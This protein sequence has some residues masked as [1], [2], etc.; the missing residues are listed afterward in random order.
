LLKQLGKHK[1]SVSCL[2][3]KNLEDVDL[4]VLK[5]LIETSVKKMSG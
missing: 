5:T 3:I 1:T 4:N 2:Y